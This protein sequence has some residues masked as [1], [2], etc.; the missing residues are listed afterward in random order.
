[1]SL[2]SPDL[3]RRRLLAGVGTVLAGS[4]GLG[5]VEYFASASPPTKR[6]AVIGHRGAAGLAPPNTVAGIDRAL[7][8][9]VDGIE[10][11][12]RQTKDDQLVLYHDPVLD[13]DSTGTGWIENTALE[14]VQTARIGGEPV[15]TLAEGLEALQRRD[16]EVELYLEV[17][18]TGYT[19]AVIETAK[20]HG[21]EDLL[22]IVSFSE[23]VLAQA[24]T[25]G[26]PTGYLGGVVTPG[27]V[28]AAVETDSS[29]V[30]CHYTPF[31]TSWFADQAREA[32]L[33][34]G[35][36]KLGDTDQTIQNTLAAEPDV[37]V[38][39]RPDLVFEQLE[40]V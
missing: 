29:S 13:W 8:V 25:T 16:A 19:D 32:A 23:D 34:S 11:D 10:L 7:D 33:T 1:M 22:T 15:P 37:V 30:L 6:P 26:V 17:K 4:V 20:A 36:W 3:S 38:T 5:S 14:A 35:V 12:V 2:H 24:Q 40:S 9:G 27:V 31:V 18:S 39:N 28:D 21:F